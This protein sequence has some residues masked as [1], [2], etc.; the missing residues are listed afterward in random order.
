MVKRPVSFLVVSDPEILG[1][2]PVFPGTR[3]PVH[4]IAVMLEQGSTGADILKAYPRR[5]FERMHCSV[6]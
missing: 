2:D 3:V 4:L 6:Y 5:W 1:G